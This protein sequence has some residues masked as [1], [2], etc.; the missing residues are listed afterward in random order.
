[1]GSF[2]EYFLFYGLTEFI[3]AYRSGVKALSS[4][5]CPRLFP[6]SLP[7][8]WR[9]IRPHLFTTTSVPKL[10]FTRSLAWDPF[11]TTSVPK[12]DFLSPISA[13]RRSSHFRLRVLANHFASIFFLPVPECKHLLA[14]IL[15]AI[16]VRSRSTDS[17][18]HIFFFLQRPAEVDLHSLFV[19]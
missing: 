12:T 13:D 16:R 1:M 14:F 7:G 2:G 6:L 10:F 4:S 9:E 15:W 5:P 11:T 17:L 3:Y 8:V 18:T 19:F